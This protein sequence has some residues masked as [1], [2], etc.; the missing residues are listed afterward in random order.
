MGDFLNDLHE[1]ILEARIKES[2]GKWL[3]K[4]F[5]LIAIAAIIIFGGLLSMCSPS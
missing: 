5:L 3:M 4:R 1:K 2:N